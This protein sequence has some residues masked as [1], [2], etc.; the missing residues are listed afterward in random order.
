M[1]LSKRCQFRMLGSIVS[2]SCY[3]PTLLICCTQ[4]Y[5]CSC[6]NCPTITN[7]HGRHG[8]GHSALQVHCHCYMRLPTVTPNPLHTNKTKIAPPNLCLKLLNQGHQHPGTQLYMVHYN[9]PM[10]TAATTHHEPHYQPPLCNILLYI[11][12]NAE[13]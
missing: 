12:Y 4:V 9:D 3:L 13:F 7:D 6:R 11:I 8:T 5:G 2:E 10:S 1:I